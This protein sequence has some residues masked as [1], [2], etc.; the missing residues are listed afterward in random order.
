MGCF[1]EEKVLFRLK[2]V[3]LFSVICLPLI[4]TACSNSTEEKIHKH[5]EEAVKIENEN[6]SE[7]DSSIADLEQHEQEIYK[8]IIDLSLDDYDKIKELVDAAN[9]NIDERN[10]L[11][12]QEND[13][14]E[15]SRKEFKNTENLIEKL[16]DKDT[17]EKAENMYDTMMER[18]AAYDDL[19]KSYNNVLEKEK[20]L[21]ELFKEEETDQAKLADHLND[22]NED[23]E[24]IIETNKKFNDE[25]KNYNKLKKE[26]YNL[27]ELNVDY[28]SNE[29]TNDK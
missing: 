8:E 28:E 20:T 1:K 12:Q 26:F 27:T 29:E 21:Y 13:K 14:Y 10:E 23:Y 24:T 18:Y 4:F 9:E 11:L 22:L 15:E 5:L 19:Y 16:S 6:E 17:K 3:L 7:K 25:T 2:K